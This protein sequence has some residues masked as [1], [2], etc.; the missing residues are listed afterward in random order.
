MVLCTTRDWTESGTFPLTRLRALS[1]RGP[2][3]STLLRSSRFRRRSRAFSFCLF[4]RRFLAFFRFETLSRVE[5]GYLF[6]DSHARPE[7]HAGTG[8]FAGR[9]SHMVL[10]MVPLFV[11]Q[12]RPPTRSFRAGPEQRAILLR[13]L[14]QMPTRSSCPG[15][16]V[17]GR[18]LFPQTPPPFPIR[19][20]VSRLVFSRIWVSVSAICPCLFLSPVPLKVY[21]LDDRC[22]PEPLLL[23]RLIDL[24][25]GAR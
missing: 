18:I 12:E 3:L 10:L 15:S 5:V 23:A 8:R 9:S 20:P 19:S 11:S 13:D 22:T 4:M 6:R 7:R 25:L 1:F 16:L 24:T 2:W 17:G 21:H 14:L